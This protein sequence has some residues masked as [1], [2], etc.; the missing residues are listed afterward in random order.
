MTL[1]VGC[2]GGGSDFDPPRAHLCFPQ[3][4]SGHGSGGE[5]RDHMF[6]I[7]CNMG[8]LMHF[9]Y[10]W[11]DCTFPAASFSRI[12][13]VLKKVFIDQIMASP[14][15]GVWYFLGMG[16]LAGQKLDQSWQELEDNFWE[17]YKIDWYMW[18]LVQ[19]NDFLFLPAAYRVLYMNVITLGWNTYLSYLKH[20]PKH[21]SL[22][23]EE[24]DEADTVKIEMTG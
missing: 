3:G 2:D 13:S 12:H 9:W 21:P 14:A 10:L 7:R 19:L 8:P 5:A 24:N 16:S 23:V 18:P 17:F 4:G 1:Q 15:L 20:R 6:A 11:L 22:S